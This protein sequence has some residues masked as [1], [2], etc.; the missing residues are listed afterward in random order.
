MAGFGNLL[1]G[2]DGFG[3]VVA[4]RLLASPP[5][6]GVAV[7]DVGIGGI[8]AVQTLLTGVSALV[9]LDAVDLGRPVG[10]LVVQAPSIADA[11]AP[12]SRDQLA[13]MHFAT[14]ER[15]LMLARGLGVLPAHVLLVGAQVGP[16]HLGQGLSPQ[17]AAAVE[18]AC[19]EVRRIAGELGIPW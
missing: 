7:L 10:T 9:V 15:A 17:V 8:H 2:D 18:P 6:D 14:P 3:V 16:L 11:T 5:P 19:R 13:D 1:R 12:G 4:E